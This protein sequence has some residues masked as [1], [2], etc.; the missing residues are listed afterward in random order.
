MTSLDDVLVILR[1]IEGKL[2]ARP[3]TAGSSEGGGDTLPLEKLSESWAN[4]TV[5]KTSSRWKHRDVVGMKYSELTSEEALDLAGFYEWKAAKGREEVPVRMNDKGKPWHE[6]DSFE[7]KILRTWA[8]S[9][10]GKPPPAPKAPAADRAF[11]GF[12]DGDS[13]DSEEIP[14]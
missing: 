8:L 11:D 12:G 14:F 13:A 7:A 2:D 10:K 4:K 5:R 1:R 9:A 6:S 3:S